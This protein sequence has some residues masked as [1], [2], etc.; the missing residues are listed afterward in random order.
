MDAERN[1]KAVNGMFEA[2]ENILKFKVQ[3]AQSVQDRLDE[4]KKWQEEREAEEKQDLREI[5]QMAEGLRLS[6]YQYAS[7]SIETSA[8]FDAYLTQYD[9]VGDRVLRRL[10]G[11][12]KNPTENPQ[13]GEIFLRRGTLAYYANSFVKAREALATA[14]AFYSAVREDS[15][16]DLRRPCS[17]VFYY[18]ALIEKN[19]GSLGKAFDYIEEAWKIHGKGLDR[20]FLTPVTRAE[21]LLYL[22]NIKGARECV[23]EMLDRVKNL[24]AKGQILPPYEAVFIAR[25]HMLL[26]NSYYVVKDWQQALDEYKQALAA[27]PE[28]GDY[29]AQYSIA[30]TLDKLGQ[31]M[32]ARQATAKA[33]EMLIQSEHL[34]TKKALDT[35]ILLN[36]LAFRCSLGTNPSQAEGYRALVRELWRNITRVDGLEMRLFSLEKKKQID[37]DEFLAEL[38]GN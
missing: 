3:E 2:I 5:Q 32:E 1:I 12:T 31:S 9:R 36:M 25:G 16:L 23:N 33:Y 22:D 26:G 7:P 27:A 17:F 15:H 38:E 18:L 29:Y 34:K 6:R 14:R 20:E 19:H 4:F 10:T 30:Q 35:R 37:K 11:A 13:F 28:D 8:R 24:T 21:I